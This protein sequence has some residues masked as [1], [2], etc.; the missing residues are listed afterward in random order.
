MGEGMRMKIIYLAKI[1]NV[2]FFNPRII[3]QKDKNC[4]R[5]F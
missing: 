2:S 5:I 4:K 1:Q 3:T